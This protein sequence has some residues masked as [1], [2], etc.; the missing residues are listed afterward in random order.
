MGHRRARESDVLIGASGEGRMLVG[1]SVR[2][3]SILV[4]SRAA[5]I[6]MTVGRPRV[7]LR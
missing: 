6:A 1:A 7:V 2:V 3:D 4:A 5:E